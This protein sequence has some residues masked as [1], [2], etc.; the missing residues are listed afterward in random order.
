VG[1]LTDGRNIL[2]TGYSTDVSPYK[3]KVRT[4]PRKGLSQNVRGRILHGNRALTGMIDLSVEELDSG[5]KGFWTGS[6]M[7]PP[8]FDYDVLPNGA[9]TLELDDGTVTNI[10]VLT[11]EESG[12]VIF[13]SA[14]P[15]P[16]RS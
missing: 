8:G 15:P 3:S 4:K 1:V 12:K 11:Q 16:R 13:H 7:A 5:A 9:A 14:P 2:G 10:H 6:F